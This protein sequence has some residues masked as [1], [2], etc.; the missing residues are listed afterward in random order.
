MKKTYNRN[1]SKNRSRNRSK[2][3]RKVRNKMRARIIPLKNNDATLIIFENNVPKKT[4]EKV[5]KNINKN[6]Y[7][8]LCKEYK[9]T[10]KYTRKQKGGAIGAIINNANSIMAT[11]G[12][13][14]RVFRIIRSIFQLGGGA[15]GTLVVGASLATIMLAMNKNGVEINEEDEIDYVE[16]YK[17]DKKHC[18]SG[19]QRQ[20]YDDKGEPVGPK[21]CYQNVKGT[22]KERMIHILD[23][24]KEVL[25]EED[26]AIAERERKLA[27]ASRDIVPAYG[28][29]R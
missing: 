19:I 6:E 2:K 8:K 12:P 4:V 7:N 9:G 5:F 16:L 29:G 25:A 27:K 15:V 23:K 26:E 1:R 13:I 24:N 10:Y 17:T 22:N 28:V 11:P 3:T 20:N 21:L 18:L 14:G